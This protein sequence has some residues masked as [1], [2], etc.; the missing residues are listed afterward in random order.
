MVVSSPFFGIPKKWQSNQNCQ[1]G[2]RASERSPISRSIGRGAVGGRGDRELRFR[3]FASNQQ[4]THRRIA[5][6][7][8]DSLFPSLFDSFF[9]LLGGRLRHVD[10]KQAAGRRRQSDGSRGCGQGVYGR[11]YGQEQRT[12]GRGVIDSPATAEWERELAQ[13]EHAPWASRRDSGLDD[14]LSTDDCGAPLGCCDCTGHDIARPFVTGRSAERVQRMARMARTATASPQ[15][16]GRQ[17]AQDATDRAVLL[18][19]AQKQLSVN[20][21]RRTMASPAVSPSS[22]PE[23]AYKKRARTPWD[24]DAPAAIRP[25]SPDTVMQTGI[26]G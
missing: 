24:E 11:M 14:P 8:T 26:Q 6:I 12:V 18:A 13:L 16:T 7:G 3:R 19:Q 20:A 5:I 17:P 21:D 1:L 15:T 4:E 23:M 10:G 2:S 9:D 25:R 22:T